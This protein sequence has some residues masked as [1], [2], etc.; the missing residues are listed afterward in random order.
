MKKINS[1]IVIT[2]VLFASTAFIASAIDQTSRPVVRI[3]SDGSI[4][5]ASAPILREGNKY[6]FTDDI[7]AELK[8]EKQGVTID[9]NG[10]SLIGPYDGEETLWIIGEGPDQELTED[11]EIWTTG[12]DTVANQIGDYTIQNLNI[13]NFSIGM[14]LWTERNTVTKNSISNC[15]VG[16]MISGNNSTITKNY[17]SNNKNGI[18]FGSNGPENIPSGMLISENCFVNNPNQLS[19][20]VCEGKNVTEEIHTWDNGYKGNYWSDYS[21]IDQNNDGIGDSPYVIDDLNMD[22]Y[23]LIVESV[24][25]PKVATQLQTWIIVGATV[26]LVIFIVIIIFVIRRKK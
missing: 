25:P 5:P 8:I 19:G 16:I 4:D 22:R 2:I 17:I 20:C 26:T 15:I 21:G 11:F 3:K 1:V 13:K 24:S 14:Y 23:P 9:G 10:H 7:F 6:I 12:I 18:Y